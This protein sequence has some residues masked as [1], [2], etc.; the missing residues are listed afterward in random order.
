VRIDGRQSQGPAQGT[1]GA[2]FEFNWEGGADV[3]KAIAA[4]FD[5]DRETE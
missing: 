4:S 2:A 5:E 1:D 3:G